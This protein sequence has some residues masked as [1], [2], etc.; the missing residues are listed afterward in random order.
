M[1]MHIYKAR[2]QVMWP[3][4]LTESPIDLLL[5]DDDLAGCRIVRVSDRVIKN[6]DG[7]DNLQQIRRRLSG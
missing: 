3:P 1:L 2:N 7:T 6:A 4:K 5:R